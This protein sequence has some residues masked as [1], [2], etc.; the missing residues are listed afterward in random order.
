MKNIKCSNIGLDDELKSTYKSSSI[1]DN[2]IV[3]FNSKEAAEYL[4][5]TV[6]NLRVK[7]SRGEIPVN[8]R[9]GKSLRFRREALDQLLEI[10]TTGDFK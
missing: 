7:V 2:R 9:L 10:S 3:W 8:G 6:E 4:R 5:I 1:F